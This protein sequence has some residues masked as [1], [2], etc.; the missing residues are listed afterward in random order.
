MKKTSPALPLVCLSLFMLAAVLFAA[1]DN[2]T[3]V[4]VG[5]KASADCYSRR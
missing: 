3:V 1:D 5:E 2:C 4:A